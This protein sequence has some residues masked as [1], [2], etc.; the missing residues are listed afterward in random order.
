MVDENTHIEEFS[1]LCYSKSPAN[2]C[3]T[4]WKTQLLIGMNLSYHGSQKL[5]QIWKA[6]NQNCALIVEFIL[7]LSTIQ[8]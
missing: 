5:S 8:K 1:Y 6:G 2:I 7:S 3:D 4:S